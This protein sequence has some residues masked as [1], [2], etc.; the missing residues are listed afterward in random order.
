MWRA[1][2]DD[3]DVF[4]PSSRASA[5][6]AHPPVWATS[7]ARGAAASRSCVALSRASVEV[8]TPFYLRT[9]RGAVA[10]QTVGDGERT[11]VWTGPPWISFASRWDRPANV[12]LLE[13]LATLGR[14]VLFDYRGFGLSEHLAL[15]QIASMEQMSFDLASVVRDLAAGPTVV[16]GTG[17][18]ARV[19]IAYAAGMPAALDRLVLLNVANVHRVV[20]A[21]GGD[22]VDDIRDRWGSGTVLTLGVAE[23]DPDLSR[24]ARTELMSATPDV[25]AAAFR[26]IG[27]HDVRDLLP[28][29]TVPTLVVHT[30]D[31]PRITP[32]IVEEIANGIP[33]AVF[34]VRPS[35]LFNW[36]EWDA[37]LKRFITGD[38]TATIGRRDLAAILFTDVV[39]STEHAARL[40]DSLWREKL[41]LLDTLVATEV[42]ARQGRVVKQTG[43]GHLVEFARP[44]DALA[45]AERLCVRTREL[46][47]QLRTG[48]HFG[49]IERRPDGDVGGLAVH[50]A[51]RIVAHAAAGEILVSRT[52]VDVTLGDGRRY[53]DRGTPPLKGI[54]GEWQMHALMP[55]V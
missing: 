52:I 13:F 27:G 22:D 50:L 3:D 45:C 28:R 30:G 31:V 15:D 49:E 24:S 20:P 6:A 4:R 12:R 7:A 47:L 1:M 53:E 40:G 48:L 9:P 2:S 35:E 41:T 34:V 16:I 54:P 5:G 51:A 14:V 32:D 44:S 25:I 46:D 23:D 21:A 19:A 11:I 55:G 33:D 36:G 43:D 38:P 42:A 18:A 29:V 10:C 39:D 8:L 17:A 37:D 26:A